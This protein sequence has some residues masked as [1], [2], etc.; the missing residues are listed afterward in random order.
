MNVNVDSLINEV[1]HRRPLWDRQNKHH[2]NR[3]VLDKLWDEI[4]AILNTPRLTA[5][6]KW[7][8]L[9]DK[10]RTSL[11]S[12][13][14]PH[15]E[16]QI[17]DYDGEWKYFSSLF[18]L[19]EQFLSKKDDD[20]FSIEDESNIL[21]ESKDNTGDG[22]DQFYKENATA[23]KCEYDS[24]NEEFLEP[25]ES[26]TYQNSPSP[27]TTSE[28]VNNRKRPNYGTVEEVSLY[29]QGKRKYESEDNEDLNFFKSLL[30]HVML[31]P[32]LD[33]MDYRIKVIRLTQEFLRN[34]KAEDKSANGDTNK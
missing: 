29:L 5:R 33:K 12:I 11:A 32:A 17:A 19:K 18:F 3:Y 34:I 28:C 10:F 20:A 22:S 8:N 23:V 15:G 4:S 6:K 13:S 24:C 14:K 2:H 7:K 21:E 26:L 30:P 16:A 25:I 9:R 27:S 31:M 1:Y